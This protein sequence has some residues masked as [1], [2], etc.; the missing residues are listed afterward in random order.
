MLQGACAESFLPSTP[1]SLKK[2]SH[3]LPQFV[4]TQL[5]GQRLQLS[6]VYPAALVRTSNSRH[7]AHPLLAASDAA[8]PSAALPECGFVSLS[9]S[10]T[11]LQS[12]CR[13][14]VCWHCT[15]TAWNMFYIFTHLISSSIP[16]NISS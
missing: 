3:F 16:T 7:A 13:V 12:I 11:H 10:H 5:T 2:L 8:C 15:V 1:S 14:Y 4:C 9:S 6:I